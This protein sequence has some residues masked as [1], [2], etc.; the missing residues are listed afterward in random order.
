MT[1]ASLWKAL[2]RAGCGRPVGQEE[3]QDH[4][5]KVRTKTTPWNV[6][7]KKRARSETC[8]TLA[9]DLSIWICES[10]TSTAMSNNHSDPTL[11]LV[12]AR[13]LR[14]LKIGIKLVVVIEGKRRIRG[15]HGE[16]FTC[17]KRR[18]GTRFWAACQRCE[19]MLRLLGVPV[20]RAKA[21]GEALCAL[22][23]KRGIV[24]GVISNDGDCFLFGARVL[25]TKF[26][27][28]NL[29]NKRVMR[30]D[31][32]QIKACVD[33]VDDDEC[34]RLVQDTGEERNT[35]IV[36]LSRN[37]LIAFAILAGS[38]LAGNGISQ[39]GCRKAVRFVKKCQIDNPLKVENASIDELIS[40]AKAATAIDNFHSQLQ[41]EPSEVQRHCSCCGHPGNKRDHLKQGCQTCG[42][43]A[44]EPCFQVSPGGKFR[45]SLRD[46]A[47]LMLPKFNPNAVI[48]IYRHP[49]DDQ[50]PVGF[51]GKDAESVTMEA[52]RVQELLR[53]SFIVK[54]HGIS[55][56][57]MYLQR[58]LGGL[59]AQ[60]E[61]SNEVS[62][63]SAKAIPIQRL[64]SNRNRAIPKEI[65][66]VLT[67]SGVACFEIQWLVTATTTDVDGNPIDEFEFSTVEEQTT[68]KKCYPML[69][70]TYEEE[71]RERKKQGV[72]EQDRRKAFLDSMCPT[73]VYEGGSVHK[74]GKRTK[75]RQ[76]KR[77]EGF[78]FSHRATSSALENTHLSRNTS[79]SRGVH[80][81]P[82][83]GNRDMN[84][85][86]GIQRGH[87][88]QYNPA[89]A[90]SREENH[91]QWQTC[92]QAPCAVDHTEK[93]RRD[94]DQKRATNTNF[95][96]R[97]AYGRPQNEEPGEDIYK[98]VDVVEDDIEY[99]N[100]ISAR[101]E[102][103]CASHDMGISN[104]PLTGTVHISQAMT[105]GH[106]HFLQKEKENTEKSAGYAVLKSK[107][108][109]SQR[110]A[111]SQSN[112]LNEDDVDT[113]L[114]SYRAYSSDVRLCD[115]IVT[116][117]PVR[118]LS[119]RE[120]PNS[121]NQSP[122][123]KR[124][125]HSMDPAC[126]TTRSYS[127]QGNRH[128]ESEMGCLG[129][130]EPP[131]GKTSFLKTCVRN[132]WSDCG[133]D[134]NPTGL[135]TSTCGP[136]KLD[137]MLFQIEQAQQIYL[138]K[139]KCKDSCIEQNVHNPARCLFSEQQ[140]RPKS[141][142]EPLVERDQTE[143][144]HG[145]VEEVG[146]HSRG[147]LDAEL[148]SLYVPRNA[149]YLQVA[150]IAPMYTKDST[151]WQQE[152]RT[153]SCC[154]QYYRSCDFQNQKYTSVAD[155]TSMDAG[156]LE[157]Y[158]LPSGGQG[159]K[160]DGCIILES[161]D[162]GEIKNERIPA[163]I[164]SDYTTIVRAAERKLRT[165]DRQVRLELDCSKQLR[166]AMLRNSERLQSPDHSFD[167]WHGMV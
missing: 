92:M 147:S 9:V 72:A 76:R 78:F 55:E 25:Y 133:S 149:R 75:S 110:I 22:L 95:A 148:F 33:Y 20:V 24:D 87:I 125:R 60:H 16:L 94:E 31:A 118:N 79:R 21:E 126:T 23:N 39:V 81:P 105:P 64:P 63:H 160:Y 50:I 27:L 59:L 53:S 143:D 51:L 12:Y 112:P 17:Q 162:S 48:E 54:G 73:P 30:Y 158:F 142:Q 46:K 40:W 45:R 88:F 115:S 83:D 165:K 62:K 163:D 70:S 153:G 90:N 130:S 151:G 120:R 65:N 128:C 144:S 35:D 98:S 164:A 58:S 137:P 61:L 26:S 84:L 77:R 3:L 106:I 91:C 119:Y 116:H 82:C 100:I 67:R 36:N 145:S 10:L 132:P 121:S 157:A 71:E 127:N 138:E 134:V 80:T 123:M 122:A 129:R 2:D 37:D 85:Y 101:S 141:Q 136:E 111:A 139:W 159:Y 109:K 6:N 32:D 44:G 69:V 19:E 68:I 104:Q 1:V 4:R 96:A 41:K 7:Q 150:E 102:R 108:I 97:C 13:T 5:Q 131:M 117:P 154:S 93:R 107:G 146:I 152:W 155:E 114:R 161:I 43:E 135:T 34:D 52:P 15:V 166:S 167:L 140:K 14:L 74:P 156:P 103:I 8:P 86:Q 29:D 49:N 56:S 18:S 66:K 42:T 124:R 47:L 57:R 11:Q 28:E 99:S 89:G 113:A 38:D